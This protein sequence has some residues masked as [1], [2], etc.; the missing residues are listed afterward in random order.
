MRQENWLWSSCRI[1]YR[2]LAETAAPT[3]GPPVSKRTRSVTVRVTAGAAVSVISTHP[4]A[5]EIG[6]HETG[7]PGS[8]LVANQ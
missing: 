6:H 2:A 8:G 7:R 1:G 3:T 5:I 4:L